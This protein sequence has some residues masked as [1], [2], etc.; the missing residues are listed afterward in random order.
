MEIDLAGWNPFKRKA[1]TKAARAET[2][3]QPS[4]VKPLIREAHRRANDAGGLPRF[5]TTA[6]DQMSGRGGDR[7]SAVRA[8]LRH[9]FTPSQ[10]VADR[11]LFAGRDDVLKTVIRAIEDQRLH[12]V[13][14]GERGIGKTSLLHVLSQAANEARYIVVYTS[15]GANSNFDETFRAAAA[16]IPLLFHSGFSPTAAETE[17]GSTLADLLPSE[18]LSPRKFGDLCAKLTGTRVLIILDEFDR[19][20]SGSFR[21]DVAELIKNL[22]DRLGRVQLV[23]AGVAAD[24]TEL[25]E[26]IPSIR[27]NIFALRVPKMSE[28]EVMQIVANG[29]REA[30]LKFDSQAG[31]FVVEVARGSPYIANLICHHAGHAALDQGRATVSPVDVASAVDRAILEFQG[32]IPT[33]AQTQ[34]R[35]LFDQGRQ[36]ALAMSARAALAADGV[37]DGRDIET[38]NEITARKAQDAIEVLVGE[39]LLRPVQGEDVNQRYA[40]V[41]EGLPT[42]IWMMWAQRNLNRE[43]PPAAP[44]R[45]ATAVS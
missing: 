24:L 14:Y 30:D 7:F 12:V 8:K 26:H 25:V 45:T 5:N 36:D 23:L 2:Q 1:P 22:S 35:R 21:R 6:S 33:P 32:R 16:E 4:I 11:R 41:E 29:E 44:A 42:L 31:A 9:A 40:F 27:R 17:K 20:E 28:G 3:A 19:A 18:P 38:A 43:A 13:L 15:C 37:F 10:P 39:R 34:V